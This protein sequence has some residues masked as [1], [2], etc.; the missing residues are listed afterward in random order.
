MYKRQEAGKVT[1]GLAMHWP[2]VTGL[3]VYPPTGSKAYDREMSTPSTLS[4]GHG[5][6]ILPT[7]HGSGGTVLLDDG[8]RLV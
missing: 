3:V 1:V 2:C 4:I 5:T 8:G 7:I 6:F